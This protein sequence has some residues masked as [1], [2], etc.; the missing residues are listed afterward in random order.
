MGLASLLFVLGGGSWL[1][2]GIGLFGE[3]K[4]GRRRIGGLLRRRLRE[5]DLFGKLLR[6]GLL[7]FP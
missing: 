2:K 3:R 5:R 7:S 1:D 6:G 4:R